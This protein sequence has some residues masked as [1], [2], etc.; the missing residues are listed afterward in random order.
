M[1]L[2]MRMSQN[3]LGPNIQY[4]LDNLSTIV[5]NNF[6][7]PDGRP[8]KLTPYQEHFIKSVLSRQKR[9]HLFVASTTFNSLSRDH[10]I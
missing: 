9:R 6:T 7:L 10:K 5:E 2:V 8:V 3:N 4:V 1:C